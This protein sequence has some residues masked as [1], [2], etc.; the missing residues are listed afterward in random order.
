MDAGPAAERP[1]GASASPVSVA[2]GAIGCQVVPP[3]R[4]RAAPAAGTVIP[5]ASTDAAWPFDA[6]PAG[7][8]TTDPPHAMQKTSVNAAGRSQ[9]GHLRVALAI[10][11]GSPN[12]APRSPRAARSVA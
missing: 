6:A 11:E 7:V 12:S 1:D 3:S 9:R 4:R 10:V 5:W 2:G 8:A